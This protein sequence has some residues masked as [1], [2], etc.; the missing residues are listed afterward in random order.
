MLVVD[1]NA[2]NRLILD[3]MLASWAMTPTLAAGAAEAL[4][5]LRSA[6]DQRQPYDLVLV[7]GH[8]PDVDGFMLAQQISDD[9]LLAGRRS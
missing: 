5:A 1:D 4:A 8:M 7:D 2:T 3:E 9:E 6:I